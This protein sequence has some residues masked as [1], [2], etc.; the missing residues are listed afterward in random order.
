MIWKLT[1]MHTPI[2]SALAEEITN[3]AFALAWLTGPALVSAS[4]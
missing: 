2:Q 4:V 3:T 1:S